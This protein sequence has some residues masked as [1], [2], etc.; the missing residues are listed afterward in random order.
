MVARLNDNLPH[1]RHRPPKL[2][3]D[4]PRLG[5]PILFDSE[6]TGSRSGTSWCRSLGN[7]PLAHVPQ[8]RF[9]VPMGIRKVTPFNSADWVDM[10]GFE[11]SRLLP[12][13]WVAHAGIGGRLGFEERRLT[14]SQSTNVV[15]FCSW[16]HATGA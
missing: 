1:A 9:S 15:H 10:A 4:S 2:K 14:T 11:G 16:Q 6:R 7:A 3:L 12:G 13:T 8:T 5:R